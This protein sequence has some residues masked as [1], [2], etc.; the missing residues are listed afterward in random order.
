MTIIT[1]V[2]TFRVSCRLHEPGNPR[3]V[4]RSGLQYT[5]SLLKGVAYFYPPA[6]G[7]IGGWWRRLDGPARFGRCL[8]RPM[9]ALHTSSPRPHLRVKIRDTFRTVKCAQGSFCSTSVLLLRYSHDSFHSNGKNQ[10][11]KRHTA[12][13]LSLIS[14]NFYEILAH[15]ENTVRNL[16]TTLSCKEYYSHTFSVWGNLFI[17]SLWNQRQY[18]WFWKLSSRKHA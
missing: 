15:Y 10:T 5:K 9:Q 4:G 1:L 14:R 8:G 7:A 13:A 6:L 18:L 2:T 11:S 12:P 3:T 17:N 16:F